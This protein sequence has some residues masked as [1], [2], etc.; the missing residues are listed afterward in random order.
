[1]IDVQYVFFEEKK[2]LIKVNIDE[3]LNLLNVVL[4]I[5]LFVQYEEEY[6]EINDFIF[7]LC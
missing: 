5:V 4:L 7:M 1:M 2:V 3:I 6:S